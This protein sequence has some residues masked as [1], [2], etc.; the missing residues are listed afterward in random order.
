MRTFFS[1]HKEDEWIAANLNPPKTGVFVEVGASHG[2]DD[3][4]TKYFEDQGWTGLCIEPHPENYKKLAQNR[5]CKTLNAAITADSSKP[6]YLDTIEPTWS[7]QRT[8][9]GRRTPFNVTYKR[10][11]EALREAG[12]GHI[13]LLSIDTEGSEL[14]VW[15]SFDHNIWTPQIVILEWETQS[16]YDTEQEIMATFKSLPYRLAHKTKGNL[17]FQRT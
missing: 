12:I 15:S 4:N 17:I 8:Q 1:Q 11:D 10:L 14:D 16:V 2:L 6:F 5:K 3:S 9:A 13:D 7:G